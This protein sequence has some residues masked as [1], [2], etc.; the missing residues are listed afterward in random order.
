[1]RRTK[2]EIIEEKI[3]TEIRERSFEGTDG[4]E[5]IETFKVFNIVHKYLKKEDTHES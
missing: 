4:L 1:M 5:Y 2:N 3:L